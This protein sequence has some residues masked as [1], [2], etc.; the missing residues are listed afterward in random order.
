[1]GL[2]TKHQSIWG[3]GLL[4]STGWVILSSRLFRVSSTTEA[5]GW[6]FMWNVN[7]FILCGWQEVYPSL[8]LLVP[9]LQ[10]LFSVNSWPAGQPISYYPQ[11]RLDLC[12]L[13]NIPS[14]WE[15]LQSQ[16]GYSTS[17]CFCK[18]SL[19]FLFLRQLTLFVPLEGMGR[20]LKEMWSGSGIGYEG[21]Q[22]VLCLWTW[23]VYT[24]YIL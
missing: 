14:L 16:L 18:R 7:I 20:R 9:G 21:N 15:P 4:M 23:P 1:M 3:R 12:A 11:I 6:A 17:G 22:V 13:E 5:L 19:C 24:I 2:L 10:I 8:D